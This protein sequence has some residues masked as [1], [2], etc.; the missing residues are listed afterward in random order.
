LNSKVVDDSHIVSQ[1]TSS[2]QILEYFFV[3][4]PHKSYEV[5]IWCDD[6]EHFFVTFHTPMSDHISF[7]PLVI[8]PDWGHEPMTSRE[9]ITRRDIIHMERVETYWT[10]VA[11]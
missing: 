8:N 4:F 5:I 6:I 1:L 9:T 2:R 7:I 11:C 10:V 3:E